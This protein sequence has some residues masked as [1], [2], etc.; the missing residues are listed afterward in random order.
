MQFAR[1]LPRALVHRQAVAEVFLTDAERRGEDNVLLAAQLPRHHVFYD[2][3]LGPRTRHDPFLLLETC[4]Q[5]IFVVA[6][7]YLGVSEN[8]KF[9]LRSVE[10]EVTDPDALVHGVAPAEAVLAVRIEDR[11]GDRRRPKGLRLRFE[12]TVDGREALLA[13][14]SFSWLPPGT[15]QR[16]R[17]VRRDALGLFGRPVALRVPRI[18]PSRVGRRDPAN[19]VIS[20][21]GITPD[22][23]RTARLVADTTHPTLFD[24]WVD[25][26]PGMLELEALRQLAVVAAADAG[27]V[28][29][30]SALPVG[31][32]V[33]FR[34]FAE[35]DLPL[36]C[37]TAPAGRGAGLE[38]ALEQHG[39]PVV[40]ARLTLAD[41][42]PAAG[43]AE[44]SAGRSAHGV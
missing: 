37:T 14:I 9:L 41:R 35:L 2:D 18:D 36:T 15:W 13:R 21:P 11:F 29:T 32:S 3:T 5:G 40:E 44:V 12:V 27:T 19:A 22:G 4:R 10:Y 30:A 24:H 8:D 42:D 39:T 43:L 1:T 7:R 28:R 31:L 26:V 17:D 33:R 20:P 6:H 23:G 16:M 38:C 25:H 34:R